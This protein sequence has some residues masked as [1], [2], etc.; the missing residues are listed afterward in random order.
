MLIAQQVS[1]SRKRTRLRAQAANAIEEVKRELYKTAVDIAIELVA[2]YPPRDNVSYIRTYSLQ[3]SWNVSQPEELS[4][5]EIVVTIKNT[6]GTGEDGQANPNDP[7]E[8]A[9][10]VQDAD[11]QLEIHEETGWP[12]IQEI[13]AEFA[14][15]QGNRVR[16]AINRSFR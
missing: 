10:L 6:A 2:S 14:R 9:Q 1:L 8:Y 3:N 4:N 12:T 7:R 13:Q 16:G 5:G 15:T 11:H